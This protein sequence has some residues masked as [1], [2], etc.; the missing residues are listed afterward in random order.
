MD[1]L[2]LKVSLKW[3]VSV[4]QLLVLFFFI[5]CM[6]AA[7]P[8]TLPKLPLLGQRST[9]LR[10]PAATISESGSEE[11]RTFY[12]NQTLD[13]FNYRPDS[14]AH[15]QQRY[16]MNSKYWGGANASAPIFAYLGAEADLGYDLLAIGFL[17]DNA[18]L[19][20]ALLVYIEVNFILS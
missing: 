4:L 13:H 14:Y 10:E 19:F 8:M 6:N 1:P 9:F 16:V 20:R 2:P 15:F 11:F 7:Q 17:S 5:P 3:P 18:L 12:Y